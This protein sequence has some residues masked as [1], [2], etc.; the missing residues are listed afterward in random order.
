MSNQERV[1][2]FGDLIIVIDT[3]P[4]SKNEAQALSKSDA[5]DITSLID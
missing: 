5:S 1:I 3:S 2:I 4:S